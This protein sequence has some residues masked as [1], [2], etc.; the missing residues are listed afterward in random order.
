MTGDTG[1][2]GLKPSLPP[3]LILAVDGQ[4]LAHVLRT[5]ALH[6]KT[7]KPLTVQ[8]TISGDRLRIQVKS[9]ATK[10]IVDDAG[11]RQKIEKSLAILG[12]ELDLDPLTPS[13]MALLL[14]LPPQQTRAR[15]R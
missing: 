13:T 9:A 11:L 4:A 12:A 1:H 5:A 8:A 7:E 3:E 15:R 2:K 14:A 6:F 10:A